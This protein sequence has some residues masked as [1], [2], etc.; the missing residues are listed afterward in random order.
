[1]T[2]HAYGE[3]EYNVWMPAY[4][5]RY[6]K[7]KQEHNI[8]QAK[9]YEIKFLDSPDGYE[10]RSLFRNGRLLKHTAYKDG[11]NSVLFRIDGV[12]VHSLVSHVMLISA[13]PHVK[14][15]RTVDHVDNVHKNMNIMNLQWL[16]MST[17]AGKRAQF[18]P[19]DD[20]FTVMIPN[21][22]VWKDFTLDGGKTTFKI[23]NYARIKKPSGVI[24]IGTKNRNKKYRAVALH[25]KDDDIVRQ[26]TRFY[27]HRLIWEA[28]HGAIPTDKEVLHNDSAPL[29]EDGSYRN[30]LCDLSIG[31]RQENMLQFHS[32]RASPSTPPPSPTEC[33]TVV[34][35]KRPRYA[36]NTPS[37]PTGFWLQKASGNKGC[38]VV[39]QIKR[40]TKNGKTMY[41]K[42]PSGPRHPT[43]LKIEVAKK[44]VRWVLSNHPD[45]VIYC[46]A[47]GYFEDQEVLSKL[48]DEDRSFYDEFKFREQDDPYNDIKASTLRKRV[49]SLLPSDCGVTEE[50]IP[51]YCTYRPESDAR[52]DKFTIEGHPK[53]LELGIKRQGTSETRSISTLEKYNQMMALLEILNLRK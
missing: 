25:Y 16:D 44:Y 14:P 51:K 23:S 13:F 53:L 21:D 27:V 48:N 17:N 32:H 4:S 45:M 11:D 29:H 31:T 43:P 19:K 50:M 8:Q 52:G 10:I 20:A 40:A 33:T 42:S 47:S 15:E 7:E 5:H 9:G 24:T 12:S 3:F 26:D 36:E 37:M 38:V 39:V 41:W 46:D 34:I 18:K 2:R 22:E 28:F 6:D 49:Q 30:W 1:M 35:Q